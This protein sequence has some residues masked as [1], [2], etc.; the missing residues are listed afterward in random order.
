MWVVSIQSVIHVGQ[1]LWFTLWS[2]DKLTSASLL[3]EHVHVY[4]VI[5][6][7]SSLFHRPV[8]LLSYSPARLVSIL[9]FILMSADFLSSFLDTV[10]LA[11]FSSVSNYYLK[12]FLRIFLSPSL[13]VAE[14]CLKF[15][16]LFAAVGVVVPVLGPACGL[17][18]AIFL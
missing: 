12:S 14:I 9:I 7:P 17:L 8:N 1:F 15:F 6:S 10:K 18:Y 4:L 11:P 13:L 16:P 5:L 2:S 3:L